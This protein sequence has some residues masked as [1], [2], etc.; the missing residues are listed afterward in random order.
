MALSGFAHELNRATFFVND[1]KS[2]A[3]IMEERGYSFKSASE[4]REAVRRRV[5][6][7]D[8]SIKTA[9]GRVLD[10]MW[11]SRHCSVRGPPAL[12]SWLGD[13]GSNREAGTSASF[14]RT[15]AGLPRSA[16]ILL[17]ANAQI[18][19]DMCEWCRW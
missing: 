1:G 17:H 11:S 7:T 19:L 5:R 12:A 15:N 18:G 3:V 8:F 2:V 10:A 14:P 4:W 9:D 13:P 16:V 6:G